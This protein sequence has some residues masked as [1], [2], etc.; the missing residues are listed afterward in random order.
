MD[1]L[2]KIEGVLRNEGIDVEP[3]SYSLKWTDSFKEKW[4]INLKNVAYN[5]KYIAW[6]QEA[7]ISGKDV[8]R[9]I[10]KDGLVL[11]WNLKGYH[12]G[13]GFECR[14]IK[15]FQDMLVLWYTNKGRSY[16]VK[17]EGMSVTVLHQGSISHLAFNRNRFLIKDFNQDHIVRISLSDSETLIDVFHKTANPT[18]ELKEQYDFY[19]DIT[20]GGVY[21]KIT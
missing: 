15:W 5:G 4:V 11:T 17:I 16:F 18:L 9:I 20:R 2:T 6:F 7:G 10:Y 19:Q 14:Y 8:A 13:Y 12:S 1:F 3:S 21:N